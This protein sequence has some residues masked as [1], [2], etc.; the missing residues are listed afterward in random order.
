MLELENVIGIYVPSTSPPVSE[1]HSRLPSRSAQSNLE[2]RSAAIVPRKN[3]GRPTKRNDDPDEVHQEIVHPEIVGLWPG[4]RTIMGVV[5][6]ETGRIVQRV[7][8]EMRHTSRQLQ[9]M[10]QRTARKDGIRHPK[11]QWAP[12]ELE[13]FSGQSRHQRFPFT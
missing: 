5:I 3:R 6:E 9:R 11:A 7:S 12:E 1:R 4:I 8:V 13:G 10:P 2:N